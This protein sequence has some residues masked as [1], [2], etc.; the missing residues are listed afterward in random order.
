MW[1]A[2]EHGFY[3]AVEN[4]DNKKTVLVRAR[5]KNDLEHLVAAL[6]LKNPV[7]S[8]PNADYPF[9][10]VVNKKDW[11]RFLADAGN[12]IDYPNFK[13]RVGQHDRHRA[14]VYH[15]VWAD[16]MKLENGHRRSWHASPLPLDEA[17]LLD[18]F[19]PD[20]PY[21]CQFCDETLVGSYDKCPWCGEELWEFEDIDFEEDVFF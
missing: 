2:T 1:I 17:G 19:D 16:L 15:D 12:A 6:R 21:L 3:S 14:D 9:R 5:V 20:E 18:G 4:R 8:T 10:V 13:T 7:L 11:G